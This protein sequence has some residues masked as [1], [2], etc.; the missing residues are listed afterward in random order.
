MLFLMLIFPRSEIIFGKT[1]S[2]PYIHKEGPE[3]VTSLNFSSLDYCKVCDQVINH[4]EQW[5]LPTFDGAVL[6]V[7]FAVWKKM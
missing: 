3:K 4:Y 7:A 6:V 2:N 1:S 5:L